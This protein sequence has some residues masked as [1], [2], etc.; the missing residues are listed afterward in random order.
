MDI[1]SVKQ[2]IDALNASV[3]ADSV[4]PE[5]VA[6]ILYDLLSTLQ[7][8]TIPDDVLRT[9][10]VR[11]SLKGNETDKPV[12]VALV[13]SLYSNGYKFIGIADTETAPYSNPEVVGLKLFY[14]AVEKGK[15]ARFGGLEKLSAASIMVLMSSDSGRTWAR[16]ES[17]DLSADM[18]GLLDRVSIGKTPIWITAATDATGDVSIY[19]VGTVIWNK[20]KNVLEE[21]IIDPESGHKVTGNT[22]SLEKDRIY[23]YDGKPCQWDGS[24]LLPM[25]QDDNV[26][27]KLP[28]K[29]E[30]GASVDI[31]M[32]FNELVE[33][34]PAF[35]IDSDNFLYQYLFVPDTV[36]LIRLNAVTG[37]RSGII[38][39]SRFVIMTDAGDGTVNIGLD[40][41]VSVPY[42]GEDGKLPVQVLPAFEDM[43]SYGIEYD[44]TVSPPE[45]TRIGSSDLHRR[46]P[47]HSKMKGCLLSDDGT[48][49]Q[50]LN[51]DDWTGETRDG[52]LGQVMVELP[53][54]Y[55]RKFETE[56][57]KRRVRIS[58]Y[59]LPGYHLVKKKYVSAYEATVQRS[60]TT[61]CSVVNDDADYRG[62]N[63]NAEWDGTYRTLLGRPATSLGLN[64]FRTYARKRKSGSTEWNTLTYDIQKDLFWLFAIEYATLNSQSPLTAGVSNLD[65]NQLT[66]FNNKN[67]F[68]PCGHTDS[69]GNGSGYVN[70]QMPE[71][72]SATGTIV[73]VPRY[74]GIEN[75]FGHINK[76]TDGLTVVVTSGGDGKNEIYICDDPAGFSTDSYE[77]YRLLGN[78]PQASGFITDVMF[79]DDGNIIP[80][81]ATGG[82]SSTYFC[83][84]FA[85]G[86][87]AKR[88]GVAF[89]GTATSG[90]QNGL[91]SI[92]ANNPAAY[93]MPVVG[94][95]LCFIPAQDS[96]D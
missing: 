5:M 17:A 28:V 86:S 37:D 10:D 1:S 66:N 94:T 51:P 53:D 64:A 39:L 57:N 36:L 29:L 74:R 52:S 32:T 56:G 69:L 26:V 25:V 71:E 6:S 61:L 72:Y 59:P 43:V 68:I 15:Y 48:V 42:L 22:C 84:Y 93:T 65:F 20:P 81:S 58:E 76:W 91:A 92:Y 23:V 63:N 95:R 79:G 31:G 40:K 44:V 83:D 34:N 50:Y 70:F 9:D 78:L 62:G 54:K 3:V 88:Y 13:N 73:T 47:I 55:Y 49:T 12:S 4:S 80:A 24:A 87:S 30:D 82:S 67:P 11:N 7:N 21:V 16:Q 77:S 89:G 27:V 90:L 60:T 45:C 18:S 19:D 14:I 8:I 46:L 38:N 75:P 85:V 96:Q 2:K 33:K 35:V 41:G